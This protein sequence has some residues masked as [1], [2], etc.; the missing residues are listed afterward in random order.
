MT[1]R[2]G[3][4]HES[5]RDRADIICTACGMWH[6][7]SIGQTGV[8]ARYQDGSWWHWCAGGWS[9]ARAKGENDDRN[10]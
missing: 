8:W 5:I 4:Y 1:V 3:E 2:L 6:D 9:P 7:T 10:P